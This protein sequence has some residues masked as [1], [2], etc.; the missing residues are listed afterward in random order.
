MLYHIQLKLVN[1]MKKKYHHRYQQK[2]IL[3]GNHVVHL[4]VVDVLEYLVHDETMMELL[5]VLYSL[6]YLVLLPNENKFYFFY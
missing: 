6:C 5:A 4:I 3:M 1:E 2:L